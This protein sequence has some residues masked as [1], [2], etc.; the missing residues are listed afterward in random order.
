MDMNEHF[1]LGKESSMLIWYPKVKDILNTP[2]TELLPLTDKEI[3]SIH[4]GVNMDDTTKPKKMP[5]ALLKKIKKHAGVIGYPLFLRSDQGS[6]KHN[7]E[8]TCYVEKEED[9]IGHVLNLH[10]WHLEAG[11]M[12]LE[13]NALVFREFIPLR[14]CFK[15]FNG[16]PVARERRYFVR[17]GEVVCHHPYWV[18]DAIHSYTDPLPADWKRVL[19]GL[20]AESEH[21]FKILAPLA[22]TFSNA[23]PGYWSVDFAQGMDGKW[24]LIDAA[25]GEVSW[26]P[27]DCP[28][29]PH[30][31]EPKKKVD[32]SAYL[33][34]IDKE[35]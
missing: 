28:Q 2:R 31:K 27:D 32:L 33:V 12:G 34:E 11:I 13:Y 25:R 10:A 30:P 29:N 14:S 7:W 18:E 35:E 6:G 23:V 24:W 21:E 19:A 17:D 16:M 4:R 5:D 3:Q 26:H 1:R 22:I 8:D 9:L 20:N 15:A